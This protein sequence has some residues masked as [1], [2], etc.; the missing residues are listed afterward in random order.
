MRKMKALQEKSKIVFFITRW[1]YITV[2]KKGLSVYLLVTDC[3]VIR[4]IIRTT[5]L[6]LD[7]VYY[8]ELVVTEYVLLAAVLMQF[9]ADWARKVAWRMVRKTSRL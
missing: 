3:R 7:F 5:Y 8:P 2:H 4:D 1:H 6:G 9:S